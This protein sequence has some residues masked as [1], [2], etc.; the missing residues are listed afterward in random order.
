MD[1]SCS[2][3]A[4]VIRDDDSRT[5]RTTLPL[6][7]IFSSVSCAAP[8]GWSHAPA[9]H[10]RGVTVATITVRRGEKAI[11]LRE[12]LFPAAR[13]SAIDIESHALRQRQ[14]RGVVDG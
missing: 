8:D 7:S 10:T 5:P 2:P 1:F 13:R 3:S 12:W 4:E 6:A 11:G 9:A 14:G